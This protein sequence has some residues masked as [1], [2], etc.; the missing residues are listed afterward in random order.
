MILERALVLLFASISA[1]AGFSPCGHSSSPLS[2]ASSYASRAAFSP[3]VRVASTIF[4]EAESS[5]TV[6]TEVPAFETAIYVGNISFGKFGGTI[7]YCG[8][9]I[10][11]TLIACEIIH[12]ALVQNQ[13]TLESDIRTAFAAHGSV[14]KVSI[15]MDRAT[16]SV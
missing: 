16:V 14:S 12:C 3:S 7:E 4:S 10:I 15:P 6:V 5:E 2:L 8:G 1:V 9:D 13:G 11:L